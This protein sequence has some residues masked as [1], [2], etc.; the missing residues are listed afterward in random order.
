MLA[1]WAYETTGI[2]RSTG[3]QLKGQLTFRNAGSL[4]V[5]DYCHQ[6]QHQK[7]L[8][9]KGTAHLRNAGSLGVGEHCP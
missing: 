9:L 2:K 4:G 1:A 8:S 7:Q 5:G 6:Q 3:Y